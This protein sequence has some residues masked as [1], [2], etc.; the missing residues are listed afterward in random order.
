MKKL[1]VVNLK[2][3]ENCLTNFLTFRASNLSALMVDTQYIILS[4]AT[5]IAKFNALGECIY[6]DNQ[7]YSN[8]T[9]K[10]QRIIQKAF[11]LDFKDRKIYNQ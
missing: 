4:H 10:Y 9:T 6:F 11:Y 2:D 5:I 1:Y 8:T 3:A 7:Y